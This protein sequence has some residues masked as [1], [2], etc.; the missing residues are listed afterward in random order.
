MCSSV[1]C[2]PSPTPPRPS[3]V[4][5][6]E[7]RGEIAIGAAAYRGFS[8]L[9]SQLA[10]DGGGLRVQRCHSRSAFHRG[11]ID[12]SSDLDFAF[13]VEGAKA[14]HLPVDSG[15]V[16]YARDANIDLR[17]GF[18]R[19]HVGSRSAAYDSDVDRQA[20]FQIGEAGNFLDL[21]RQLKNCV[22]TFLEIESGM[23]SLAGNFDEV[24]AHSFARRFHSAL[25]SKGR[26]EHEHCSGFF[27]QRLG[28]RSR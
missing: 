21:T 20:L 28:D 25:P 26:L 13:A 16:F 24:F 10:R 8:K 7:T 18:R 1:A 4:G 22:H 11:T 6:P 27:R 15:G 2:A 5:I 23:R 17:R 19:N 3:S 12:S 9:P 14:A